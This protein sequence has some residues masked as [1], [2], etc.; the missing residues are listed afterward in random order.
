MMGAL[1]CV[2]VGTF[3]VDE[4]DGIVKISIYSFA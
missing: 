2:L 3:I 1:W 4:D